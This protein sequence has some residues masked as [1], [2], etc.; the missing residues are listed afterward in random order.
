MALASLR[1][2]SVDRRPNGRTNFLAN[3]WKSWVL[4]TDTRIPPLLIDWISIVSSL[5]MRSFYLM[6]L[7]EGSFCNFSSVFKNFV[8]GCCPFIFFDRSAHFSDLALAR[9]TMRTY[10]SEQ[11]LEV[12]GVRWCWEGEVVCCTG[13]LETSSRVEGATLGLNLRFRIGMAS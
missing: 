8:I 13:P 4:Q 10:P 5:L 3:A 11:C 2:S 9:C 12:S 6:Y 1:T 7:S